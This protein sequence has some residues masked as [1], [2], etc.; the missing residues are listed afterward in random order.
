MFINCP[1]DLGSITD[2]VIPKTHKMV[3]DTS[4][5]NTRDDK[6]RI[7]N[8]MEQYTEKNSGHPYTSV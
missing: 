6:V 1:E 7:K 5:F 4:V 3:L 2:Q 8:K